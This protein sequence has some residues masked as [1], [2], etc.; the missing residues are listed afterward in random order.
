MYFYLYKDAASYWRWTLY[1]SNGR[2]VADSGEG[3]VNKIDAENGINLVKSS[4]NAPVRQA[5]AA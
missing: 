2:K 3:Y 1:A 4:Y 5:S